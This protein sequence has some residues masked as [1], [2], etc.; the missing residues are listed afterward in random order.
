[1]SEAILSIGRLP[2]A[3]QTA[4]DVRLKELNLP[5]DPRWRKRAD[6]TEISLFNLT[7]VVLFTD[8]VAEL[9]G[10]SSENK[11][12]E[13]RFRQLPW[14]MTSIWIPGE[15][16]PLEQPAVQMGDW[17]VFL[18][19]CEALRNE[20]MEIQKLSDMDLGYVPDGYNVMRADFKSFMRSSFSIR[21]EREIIQWVWYGLFEGAELGVSGAALMLDMA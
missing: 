14:W 11:M 12:Q 17:P 2:G 18:G 5:V 10:I 19:T 4:V 16:S 21:D 13:T 6:V 3:I 9:E 1:M 8:H 15:F 20:L 7:S